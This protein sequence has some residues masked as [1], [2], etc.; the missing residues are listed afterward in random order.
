[1]KIDS[2]DKDIQS[3]LSMGFFKIP[4]FQRPYSWDHENIQDFWD[5]VVRDQPKEYFIG[6]MVV[7]RDPQKYFCVVDGQ[8]RLTSITVLLCV[9]RN[10][11]DSIGDSDLAAGT[12]AL[13]EK[14]NIKH[15]LEFVLSTETSYPFFQH[16]IQ[17]RGLSQISSEEFE[18]EAQLK[19]AFD[20]FSDL[21]RQEVFANIDI[22]KITPRQKSK[23][24]KHLEK[25][26]DAVLGLKLILIQLFDED[27]AYIIF[28]T[29]NT[30][31]KDLSLTDLVKNVINRS[32]K[33]RN[34]NLDQVKVK[35]NK[36]VE[37]IQG[38]DIDLKTDTFL[39]HFWLSRYEYLPAKS[40]YKTL[41]KKIKPNDATQFLDDLLAD[42]TLYREMSEP[43]FR[44]WAKEEK[45]VELAFQA[46]T[47][48]RV[49][50]Q[51]P[52][53]LS[54]YRAYRA[55][56]VIKLRH[57]KDAIV[58]I[59]KFH[60]LFTAVTSQ[61]S[62][63]GISGMYAAL[64][65]KLSTT[66]DT[67]GAVGVINELRQKLRD[68]VPSQEEFSALFPE[69]LYTNSITRQTKLVKYILSGLQSAE[70]TYAS[71]D[72]DHM[73]IEHLIP[74]S[75]IGSGDY[76]DANVG[77]LGNLILVSDDLNQK[78]K[79]KEF[80]E[81]KRIL[82]EHKFPLSEHLASSGN[83]SIDDIRKRTIAL[84]TDAYSTIWKI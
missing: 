65:R 19:A 76:S 31:G 36:I 42:A 64:A 48:F 52:C 17:Q 29:L 26:R 67:Q 14:R 47:L 61:R 28:E 43:G 6:S 57:L 84:A 24:I 38:S 50:Q 13:I 51:I 69:I 23:I 72:Y 25:I 59:E 7:F 73:T 12:H 3:L 62:S 11:F 55:S 27:D 79:D 8:Q 21:V 70:P 81:K 68:R 34:Q 80:S 22:G 78:L 58:A 4:R 82:I 1:M 32:V 77:Q 33:A 15:G 44:E 39:H 16:H 18:E 37:I 20:Q 56:K 40:L 71:V 41:K 75:R 66:S 49:Q 83:W 35:W 74:Q 54:L 63:G 9:I 10:A 30:R 60:F 45:R 5:D 53:A 2:S 46:L